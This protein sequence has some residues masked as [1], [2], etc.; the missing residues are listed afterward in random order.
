MD[1][2]C[3][4]RVLLG[5]RR[6]QAWRHRYE[7]WKGLSALLAADA[8]RCW[9][10]PVLVAAVLRSQQWHRAGCYL[11]LLLLLLPAP[12]RGDQLAGR[13]CASRR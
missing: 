6:V 10:A 5:Q 3:L 1:P 8:G 9:Y 13:R 12:E 4:Y 2:S 11:L 7:R